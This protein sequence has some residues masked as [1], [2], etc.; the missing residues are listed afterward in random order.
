MF[1]KRKK[2]LGEER[3]SFRNSQSKMKF[4]KFFWVS[5]FFCVRNRL[6]GFSRS[7]STHLDL[8]DNSLVA[9]EFAGI[10]YASSFLDRVGAFPLVAEV[11]GASFHRSL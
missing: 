7:V 11:A 3:E 1:P 8:L 6:V 4:F 9:L 5:S 10:Q 2:K